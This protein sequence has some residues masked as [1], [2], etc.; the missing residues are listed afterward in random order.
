VIMY[1]ASAQE[2]LEMS[3]PLAEQRFLCRQLPDVVDSADRLQEPRFLRHQPPDGRL[4]RSSELST[5]Q[6][7]SRI[8]HA[9]SGIF[10][11]ILLLI[12]SHRK[13]KRCFRFY[14]RLETSH[15]VAREQSSLSSE[16]IQNE[17]ELVGCCS[18]YHRPTENP[19]APARQLENSRIDWDAFFLREDD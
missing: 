3:S 7:V 1:E 2:A 19:K 9:K 18:T 17:S 5:T 10:S 11:R 14:T 15:L 6:V 12:F 4:C 13:F 8:T 16:A